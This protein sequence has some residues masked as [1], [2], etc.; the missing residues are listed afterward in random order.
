MILLIV[1][2]LSFISGMA[3]FAIID[4]NMCSK[5]HWS[6]VESIKKLDNM[7]LYNWYIYSPNKMDIGDEIHIN[8]Y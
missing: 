8:N 2:V 1:W 7:Y 5:I 4:K 6:E 3:I